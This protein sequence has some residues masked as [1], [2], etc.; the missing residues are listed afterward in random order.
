MLTD[1]L[2]NNHGV[3]LPRLLKQKCNEAR[4]MNVKPGEDGINSKVFLTI[5]ACHTTDT[6]KVK[7]AINSIK[8]LEFP[9]N[10]IVIVSSENALYNEQMAE[11]VSKMYPDI[12]IYSIPN[13]SKSDI[14]KWMYYI[15]NE[16]VPNYD[17]VIFT[18]DSIY[19]NEPVYHFYRY[20]VHTN[21]EL[22]GYNDSSQEDDYHY[23]SFLYGVQKN[24]IQ[25]LV[26]H[27]NKVEPLLTGY[28][29]LINNFEKKLTTIFERKDCF[30][31]IAYIQGHRG[32]NVYFNNDSL[33][34]TLK[35]AGVMS[36]VKTK[37]INGGPIYHP[38]IPSPSQRVGGLVSAFKNYGAGLPKYL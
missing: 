36:I 1:I 26:D 24:A 9:G 21:V 33:Y 34:S 31:P 25:K 15:K 32:K 35:R 6:T 14:G 5:I 29:E 3:R 27:Y 20:M 11:T 19:Y 12:E 10:K 17:H 28:N 37:R 13:D 7:V 38:H 22:Y 8:K 2:Y 23:Q 30:L 18:N 4:K 16:Y